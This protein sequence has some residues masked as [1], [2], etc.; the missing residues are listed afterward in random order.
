MPIQISRYEKIA[1]LAALCLLLFACYQV[2]RPF[3]FDLLWAAILCFVTWPL[4]ARLRDWKLTANWAATAMVLPIGIL[5]LTPFVAA[6]LT[7]TEDINQLLQW[8]NQSRH[9]WPEPPAWLQSL[10]L[11]G[12]NAVAAWQSVGE[13]SSRLVNLARQ[14]ALSA[15][16]WV[17][18][19]G[20]GL[21][22]ELMHM[23]LAILVLFFFYR[24]GEHV[25]Q[26]VVI[27][28]E[29]L[30]GERTQRIL[31]IV[32]S[33]LRA[34]VYGILGTA[35]VQALASILG[36][37]IAGVPY[38]FVLGVIAF[39]LMI[40]PAAGTVIWLP[41]ALWLLAEGETGWA[42]FIALWFLLFV[43]TIDNWLRPILISREVELPFVLI[44]FGIFGGLLAF[45]FI[46]V[47]IGPTLLATSYALIL[48]WLIRNEHEEQEADVHAESES[49]LT[50]G[51]R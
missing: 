11:V 51:T 9:V 43:G 1:S 13:D 46:G 41:I 40:I 36:F 24:D 6:T 35:L 49:T 31:H 7:F 26:H 45:G 15:S 10:P 42:I 4:Y 2:L 17:L 28:V 34:V 8:L 3:I 25:A 20:I 37:V 38:A 27:G 33:S 23:G 19:Q 16:S 12:D 5:L 22:G 18:Q 39:F 14:Y 44:V 47:F 21:A 29:R 48:D 50:D 32:R 30:A